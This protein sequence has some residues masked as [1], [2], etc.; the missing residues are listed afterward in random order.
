LKCMANVLISAQREMGLTSSPVPGTTV[1]PKKIPK[2]PL[3]LLSFA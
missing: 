3:I 2:T 1:T